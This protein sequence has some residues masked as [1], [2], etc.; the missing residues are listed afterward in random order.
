[1]DFREMLYYNSNRTKPMEMTG[2]S[3]CRD[4]A[5]RSR[6]RAQGHVS[7]RSAD[8]G[9][10]Q[11]VSVGDRPAASIANRGAWG[12]PA[13]GAGRRQFDAKG[14]RYEFEQQAMVG[15]WRA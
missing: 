4:Q 11:A 9:L 13:A 2:G 10:V 7:Q 5:T 3:V 1:M 6:V 14:E 15:V 12:A 8:A